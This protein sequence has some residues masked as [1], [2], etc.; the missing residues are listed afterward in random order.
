MIGWTTPA[1][2]ARNI[3]VEDIPSLKP[4]K[5]VLE[6][7]NLASCELYQYFTIVMKPNYFPGLE[8]CTC[9]YVIVQLREHCPL[10]IKIIVIY[11]KSPVVFIMRWLLPWGDVIMMGKQLKT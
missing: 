7:F 6:M 4:G 5:S 10:L 11:K 8:E 3:L 1:E 2:R 9:T